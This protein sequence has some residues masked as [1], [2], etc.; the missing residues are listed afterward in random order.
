LDY[1]PERI[2]W[3]SALQF[4]ADGKLLVGG[5]TMDFYLFRYHP[6]GSPDLTFGGDRLITTNIH[7]NDLLENLLMY[8]DGRIL[9]A[10]KSYY[11]S[12]HASLSLARYWNDAPHLPL[13]V[14]LPIV[15][16]TA[17]VQ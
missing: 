4:Q 2:L 15:N 17:G 8:A 6:D 11:D 12:Q 14:W 7:G 16:L 13:R 3:P 9:A 10:G 1:R 5:G